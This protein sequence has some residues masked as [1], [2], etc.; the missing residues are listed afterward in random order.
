MTSHGLHPVHAAAPPARR[1]LALGLL[2]AAQFMLILDITVVNVAL[3]DIGADLGLTRTSVTWVVTTYTL[4]F[5]GLMLLGG[6]L[7]DLFGAHRVLY[8]G[9]ATFTVASLLAGLADEGTLLIAGRAA[10]GVGA[11]LMSPAALSIVTTTFTGTERHK[12]LGVWGMLGGTGSA[13]GVLLGGALT[14]GPGWRWIFF[15]NLPVGASVLIL[16]PYALRGFRFIRSDERPDLPGALLIT[17]ATGAFIYGLTNAGD[18]GWTGGRTLLPIG[19]AVLLYAGFW[20]WQRTARQ[21]LVD[22]RLL[23]RG[24]MPA[25]ALLMLVATALLVGGFFI[26][27]FWLQHIR[28]YSALSTGL[29][30]LPI[31]VATIAGAHTAGRAIDHAGGR[32]V[33]VAGLLLAAAGFAVAAWWTSTL[34]LITGVSLA[35]AGLGATFV[36]ATTTA[37]AHVDPHRA[38]VASGVLNTFHELGAAVGVAATSSIAAGSLVATGATTAGFTHGLTAGAIVA[39]VAAAAAAVLVPA[40]KPPA[41]SVRHVH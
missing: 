16:L 6:R 8:A 1:W 3:P 20:F 36:T 15:I 35:A 27:S 4:L 33:G 12:A 17:A 5:G 23:M 9:L 40:G 34:G 28:G 21:P 38:G 31:A 25:G 2:G 30:F 37:L 10:Q 39:V 22:L 26:G 29:A 13:I 18:D 14:A 32:L 11:A 41:G 19:A 7:A 24:A